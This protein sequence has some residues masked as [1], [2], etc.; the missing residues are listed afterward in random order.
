MEIDL[1]DQL[2]AIAASVPSTVWA[3][4]PPSDSTHAGLWAD[5]RAL[6]AELATATARE[7]EAC[8]AACEGLLSSFRELHPAIAPPY[9]RSYLF[10]AARAIRE[11]SNV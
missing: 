2:D 7:R 1:I 5:V 3:D 10:A 9:P 6:R 8:A 11:R 4:M